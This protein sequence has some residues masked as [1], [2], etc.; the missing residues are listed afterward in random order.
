[1]SLI[2]FDGVGWISW[3]R[4]VLSRVS[5]SIALGKCVGLLGPNGAGKTTMM[6]A[7]R[8]G[9]Q[10]FALSADID[11]EADALHPGYGEPVHVRL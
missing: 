2:A 7:V 5:L 3:G 9:Q 10:I 6:G 1:M 4:T 8:V 11:A